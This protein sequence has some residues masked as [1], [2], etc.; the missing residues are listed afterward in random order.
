MSR[1]AGNV[2]RTNSNACCGSASPPNA[3]T[4]SAGGTPSRA[5]TAANSR[6]YAG[7][8][9]AT[10]TRSRT[11]NACAASGANGCAGAIATLAPTASGASQHSC[12]ASK[13]TDAKCSSRSPAAIGSAA[14]SA[15]QCAASGPCST[16]TAFGVPV[17]PD[18]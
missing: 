12:A 8:N 18:V 11:I 16:T 3:S 13:L 10:L 9:A 6:R 14:A 2:F 5:A 15:S 17:E 4:R 1:T 7:G